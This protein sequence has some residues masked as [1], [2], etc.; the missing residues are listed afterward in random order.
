MTTYYDATGTERRANGID[1]K[2]RPVYRAHRP[3]LRC[4]GLGGAEQWRHTG[5]RCYRCGG[6]GNDPAGPFTNKLYTADQY[7]KLESARAKRA[8]TKAR[9]AAEAAVAAEAERQATWEAWYLPR[10]PVVDDVLRYRD[11][12]DFTR[13]VARQIETSAVR[14]SDSVIEIAFAAILRKL[15]EADLRAASRHVGTV[16][17]RVVLRLTVERSIDISPPGGY[18]RIYRYINLCRDAEGNRI[19]YI[20]NPW[21]EGETADVK[22]TIKEHNRRDGELQTLVARPK[23]LDTAE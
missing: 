20:G 15:A 23:V 21:N 2:G 3:C 14:P 17:E 10:S 16:G 9:K 11:T 6:A 13:N 4:G 8:A 18:P 5:W 1:D 7:A 12:S 22:V 19:V